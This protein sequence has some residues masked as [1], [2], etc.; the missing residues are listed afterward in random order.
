M[1][2]FSKYLDLIFIV[3]GGFIAI[4]IQADEVQNPYLL[5]VGIVVLMFGL[6]RLSRRIPSKEEEQS[7]IVEQ[8]EE[9]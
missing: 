5:V 1:S 7:F 2:Q 3:I 6:M 9:E 4:Y 8:D